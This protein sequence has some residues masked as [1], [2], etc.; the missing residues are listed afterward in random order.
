MFPILHYYPSFICIILANFKSLLIE[1]IGL[2]GECGVA[3]TETTFPSQINNVTD[4]DIV[5]YKKDR[6]I[7]SMK[8]DKDKIS[9]PYLGETAKMT[10]EEY[11]SIEQILNEI[12]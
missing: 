11:K 4:N 2:R 6:V 12:R 1:E 9:R 10:K 7:A 8:V 5:Y 3:V